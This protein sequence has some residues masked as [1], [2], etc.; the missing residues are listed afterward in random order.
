MKMA[1]VQWVGKEL[2]RCDPETYPEG[3]QVVVGEQHEKL[4]TI[5][6]WFEDIGPPK[7]NERMCTDPQCQRC[8]SV[9]GVATS[10]GGIQPC[11]TKT[12]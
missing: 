2:Q 7:V 8:L 4:P 5:V 11:G 6:H 9:A 10:F 3:S 1:Y 12:T